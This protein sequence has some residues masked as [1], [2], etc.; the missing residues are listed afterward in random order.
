MT[1]S[2]KTEMV[3]KPCAG[4][5]RMQQLSLRHHCEFLSGVSHVVD[6]FGICCG[7]DS[8]TDIRKQKAHGW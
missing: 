7:V 4:D 2:R 8:H 6:P 3:V 5:G 1:G